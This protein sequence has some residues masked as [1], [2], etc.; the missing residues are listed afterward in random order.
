MFK[1]TN[2]IS[3]WEGDVMKV[4]TY[5]Q[6]Q[7]ADK[8]VRD[9]IME[10]WEPEKYDTMISTVTGEIFQYA[11]HERLNGKQLKEDCI[12]LLTMQHLVDFIKYKADE[13]VSISG[14][15]TWHIEG[16]IHMGFQAEC[17]DD[18]LI[19]GLWEVAQQY[20]QRYE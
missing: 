4:I 2:K 7:D 19:S 8:C 11:W 20:C 12:P 14:G 1:L 10:W 3:F 15:H 18:D 17:F 16:D 13:R 5:E 6:F 9:A